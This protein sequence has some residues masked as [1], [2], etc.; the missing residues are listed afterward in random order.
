MVC[1]QTNVSSVDDFLLTHNAAWITE[2]EFQFHRNKSIGNSTITSSSYSP[3]VWDHSLLDVYHKSVRLSTTEEQR[4][5]VSASYHSY[6]YTSVTNSTGALPF[7]FSRVLPVEYF[8]LSSV[9]PIYTTT[10]TTSQECV[11]QNVQTREHFTIGAEDQLNRFDNKDKPLNLGCHKCTWCTSCFSGEEILVAH[12]KACR[13]RPAGVTWT[14]EVVVGQGVSA[15]GGGKVR[16]CPECGK[17]MSSAQALQKHMLLHSGEKPFA[18]QECGKRFAQNG[19]LKSHL[20][21]H[22]GEQPHKCDVCG[23]GFAQKG[24]LTAH[25]RTHT[26]ATPYLCGVCGQGFNKSS[27]LKK[28][29][30]THTRSTP[31]KCQLCGKGFNKRGS[32]TTHMRVHTGEKPYACPVC[33]QRFAQNG[34]MKDH[35]KRVHLSY[36]A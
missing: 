14:G 8:C 33:A 31:N 4:L 9:A 26:G 11:Q 28:H 24:N 36:N 12:R 30:L 3:V 21:T 18:C 16:Q 6:M 34:N 15:S 25:M 13:Q 22:T 2:E 32:L 10:T 27:S 23:K 5:Y 7:N 35:V 17:V 29:M 20:L 1:N 19:D